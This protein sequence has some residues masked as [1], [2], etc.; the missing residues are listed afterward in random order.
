[1]SID[2]TF[3]AFNKH[4]ADVLWQ[5]LG[6]LDLKT[7]AA[8][9]Q[10]KD[11][12]EYR[13][14][15][16][17][18]NQSSAQTAVAYLRQQGIE[19]LNELLIFNTET[20]MERGEIT[21]LPVEAEEQMRERRYIEDRL[22][23]L[24]AI[25]PE[26]SGSDFL[27][28]L[29]PDEVELSWGRSERHSRSQLLDELRVLDL[30]FGSISVSPSEPEYVYSL[31]KALLF[32]AVP[33][34]SLEDRAA[35]ELLFAQNIVPMF[36][37]ISKAKIFEALKDPPQHVV[38]ALEIVPRD[39]SWFPEAVIQFAYELRPLAKELKEQG[40]RLIVEVGGFEL[41]DKELEERAA[42]HFQFLLSRFP[43]IGE[44]LKGG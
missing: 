41:E 5:R 10:E 27:Y 35:P 15:R 13:L 14:Q 34:V 18:G 21:W 33:Q 3:F 23:E 28:A 1:M 30:R 38:E 36:E 40:G 26:I 29:W 9:H 22:A 4:R 25:P 11:E 8:A 32:V 6:T 12:L 24:P 20:A 19:V 42:L 7:L 17:T 44:R 37:A 16:L 43:W 39:L 2:I 31:M